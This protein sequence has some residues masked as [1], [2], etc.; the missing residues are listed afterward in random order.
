MS[1]EINYHQLVHHEGHSIVLV[2]RGPFGA[3]HTVVLRCLDCNDD[4]TTVENPE[5]RPLD[6][7]EDQTKPDPWSKEAILDRISNGEEDDD[8]EEQEDTS[9]EK[10]P[11]GY[12]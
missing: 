1:K 2:T 3:P 12:F 7:I 9:Q 8:E 6:T 4:I 11:P 5:A 10:M